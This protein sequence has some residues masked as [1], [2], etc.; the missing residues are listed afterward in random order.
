MLSLSNTYENKEVKKCRCNKSEYC[1]E[2]GFNPI[3]GNPLF[4]LKDKIFMSYDNRYS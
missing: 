1:K 4:C 2:C 3:T